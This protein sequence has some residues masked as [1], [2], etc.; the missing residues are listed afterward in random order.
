MQRFSTAPDV[1][2]LPRPVC[3]CLWQIGHGYDRSLKDPRFTRYSFG[4]QALV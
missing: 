3:E 4:S 2:W 1:G